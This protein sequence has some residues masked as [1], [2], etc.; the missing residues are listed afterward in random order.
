MPLLKEFRDFAMKGSVIDL[1]IGVIIG[2]AF[3]KIV[4]S[5]V[6]NIIMPPIG[7]LLGRVDFSNLFLNLSGQPAGSL[8]EATDR[9]IPVL[10]YGAF[11]NTV[12]E[13]LIIAFVLFL[14]I[15]QVNRFRGQPAPKEPS[16]EEKLL[17]EIRDVLKS[18]ATKDQTATG[19]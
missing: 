11:L 12:F 9:G 3:G 7:L 5:L 18:Q 1:A 15:R 14:V 4:N 10:A 16:A 19:K 2:A 6:N 8:K 17:G 13:F